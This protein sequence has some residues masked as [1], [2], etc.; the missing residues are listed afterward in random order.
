MGMA[1]ISMI[2]YVLLEALMMH[3]LILINKKKASVRIAFKS[4]I[5]GQY[6]SMITPFASGGQPMQLISMVEDG[7]STSHATAI[8]V[9]KFLYFQVG[10]TIY[11]VAMSLFYLS[12]IAAFIGQSYGVLG[13]GM[14]VN[15]I[16]LII[17]ALMV[18]K[19]RGLKLMSMK[20]TRGI[21]SA[22]SIERK[23]SVKQR[24]WFRKID[25]IATSTHDLLKNRTLMGRMVI[26]TAIQLT[27]YFGITYF[28]YRAFGLSGQSFMKIVTLQAVLYLSIS[29]LPSP[30]SAGVAE[31]GFKWFFGALFTSG[32]LLGAML[33]WRGISYYLNLLFSG[34][35]TVYFNV[36]TLQ[37][38]KKILQ[39]S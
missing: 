36:R 1:I 32:S 31:S 15:F 30:G 22:F 6:Y 19:P 29:L 12:D 28:I 27:A 10:V 33:V 13:F 16:G 11:A 4:T 9:N 3:L 24:R 37:N 23:H 38:N 14:A 35:I 18:L 39:S 17:L 26:L 7:V 8:L 21:R 34:I 2:A 20:I 5:I 25:A